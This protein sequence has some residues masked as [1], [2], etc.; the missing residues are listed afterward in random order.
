[1]SEQ[2]GWYVRV[3]TT[4]IQDGVYDTVLYAVGLSD[5]AEAEEAVK[6]A[7]RR[8]GERYEALAGAIVADVGPQPSAGEV[9]LLKE[10]V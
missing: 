3:T 9:R 6:K 7:R 4:E 8:S 10:A 5:P 2:I 1:M